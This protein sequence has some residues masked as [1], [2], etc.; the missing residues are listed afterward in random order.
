MK[1]EDLEIQSFAKLSKYPVCV[2]ETTGS[3]NSQMCP[4]GSLNAPSPY[5][6]FNLFARNVI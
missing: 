4:T 6:N 5:H 1:R 2:G 3:A